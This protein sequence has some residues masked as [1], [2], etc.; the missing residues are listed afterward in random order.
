MNVREKLSMQLFVLLL[1][2][3]II[4]SGQFFTGDNHDQILSSETTITGKGIDDETGESLKSSS[5]VNTEPE[6]S[7]V[8]NGYPFD[9]TT[10]LKRISP[11]DNSDGIRYSVSLPSDNNLL[12][13]GTVRDIWGLDY[14]SSTAVEISSTLRGAGAHCQIWVEDI[15][16]DTDVTQSDVDAI[17][18]EFENKIWPLA[19]LYFGYPADIDS[20]GVVNVSILLHDTGPDIAGYYWSYTQS[21]N[22]FEIFYMTKD[23]GPDNNNLM[24]TL[25][26]EFQHMIHDSADGSEERWLDEGCADFAKAL[27]GYFVGNQSWKIPY[28][29]VDP[30]TSLIY[31]DYYEDDHNV[32]VNYAMSYL[33]IEYLNEYYGGNTAIYSLVQDSYYQGIESVNQTVLQSLGHTFEEVFTDWVIANY[34]DDPSFQQFGYRNLDVQAEPEQTI[35]LNASSPSFTAN[36]AVDHRAGKAYLLDNTSGTVTLSFNGED[37]GNF[38]VVIAQYN[39][40]QNSI[41]GVSLDSNQE[42]ELVFPVYDMTYL[43]VINHEGNTSLGDFWDDQ[44]GYT[45]NTFTF[46]LTLDASPV[47]LSGAIVSVNNHLLDISELVINDL[48]GTWTTADLVG[49]NIFD[50]AGNPANLGFELEYNSLAGSW[51]GSDFDV[52]SLPA[53]QYICRVFASNGTAGGNLEVPFTVND[54]PDYWVNWFVDPDNDGDY[55]TAMEVVNVS[56]HRTDS[57]IFVKIGLNTT[58]E[59]DGDHYYLLFFDFDG[60]DTDEWAVYWSPSSLVSYWVR[61]SD[62][63]YA[64]NVH[65]VLGNNI[66]FKLPLEAELAGNT[67]AYVYGYA[68]DTRGGSSDL[69]P[70]SGEFQYVELIP[71]ELTIPDITY[72]TSGEIIIGTVTIQWSAVVD[73]WWTHEV[74]YSLWYSP[75]NGSNWYQLVTNLTETSFEWNTTSL[76]EGSDYRLKVIAN[77]TSGLVSESISSL[78]TITHTPH[79]L[80]AVTIIQPTGGDTLNG[81]VTVQWTVVS[82]SWP[83]SVTYTLWYSPDGGTTWHVLASNLI[84]TSYLWNTANV[85]DGSNYLLK[86]RAGCSGGLTV[87]GI[88]S[89]LSI[90]NNPHELSEP[91]IIYP[92]GGETL[93]GTVTIQWSPASDSWTHGVTYTLWYSPDGGTTW[94]VLAIN[95]ISNSVQWDTTGL[96]DGSS[97]LIKIVATCSGGLTVDDISEEVFTINNAEYSTTTVTETS[98]TTGNGGFSPA[99]SSGIITLLAGA[100]F[101]TARHRRSRG[102]KN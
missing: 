44:G 19:T 92:A 49:V 72:P 69:F 2:F 22:G 43:F 40:V 101:I 6:R 59:L 35:A 30:A 28:F 77:C 48:L 76:I 85:V 89:L 56:Y 13:V 51:E 68:W 38:E 36:T 11:S 32:L 45:N 95:L 67:Y 39:N 16:W 14:V 5:M 73:S 4:L 46:D 63:W 82:D 3:T 98:T 70:D 33:F 12:P 42:G 83:H 94:H 50:N 1:S 8:F 86:V 57:H 88:S 34:L 17:I 10:Y 66:I 54:S 29:E 65:F 74:N 79:E 80:L 97:Y 91:S 93:K 96:D 58:P 24:G 21:L 7:S 53:G 78:F 31:W 62:S 81:S 90:E 99:S 27:G 71:H 41:T 75:D 25:V 102:R 87:E 61:W 64:K 52:T 100:F 55:G 18:D 9:A 15:Y 60:D 20:D 37:T 23:T 26:H 84:G 47:T